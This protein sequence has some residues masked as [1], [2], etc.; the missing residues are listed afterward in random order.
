MILD[1]GLSLADTEEMVLQLHFQCHCSYMF[2]LTIQQ[3][4]RSAL[5]FIVNI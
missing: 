1:S 4:N 3:N 5:D 2:Y